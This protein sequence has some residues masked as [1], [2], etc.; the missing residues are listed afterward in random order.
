MPVG[1]FADPTRPGA[2]SAPDRDITAAVDRGREVREMGERGRQIRVRE[3][4][5]V[6]ARL[7]HARSDGDRLARMRNGENAE[8]GMDGGER[9]R[10]ITSLIGAAVIDQDDLGVRERDGNIGENVSQRGF[11]PVGF[12]VRGNNERQ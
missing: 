10:K 3:R 11:D 9:R 6:T 5:Q 8:L 2:L 1:G 12:V 7:E 4:D